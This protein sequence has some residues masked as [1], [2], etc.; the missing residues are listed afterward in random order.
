MRRILAAPILLLLGGC[1]LVQVAVPA[2]L[3][4]APRLE[5]RGR[6]GVRIHQRLSFGPFRTDPVS[7]SWTRVEGDSAGIT[8]REGKRQ[9]YSF[10]LRE[11][12][13]EVARGN[14]RVALNTST[15]HLGPLATSD[16]PAMALACD[17]GMAD[18]SVV[19]LEL[20]TPRAG[21]PER[22]TLRPR[23]PSGAAVEIEG[24]RRVDGPRPLCCETVGYHLRRDGR[25]IATVQTI[26]RGAVWLAP[27]LAGADRAT[28]AAGAAALL[29]LDEL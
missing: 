26:N 3:A 15:T 25:V 12:E 2:E 19:L 6:Q 29:L 4:T 18:N 9:R 1:S 13:S 5:A 11:G 16:A 28:V 7:R 24:T 21:H 20:A 27:E 23:D 17:F 10:T 8:A 14:C 22:G